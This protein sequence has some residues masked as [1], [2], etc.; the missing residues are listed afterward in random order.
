MLLLNYLQIKESK[1]KYFDK[2]N[3]YNL[4]LC[5]KLKFVI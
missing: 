2:T 5:D 1:N 3:L 4:S